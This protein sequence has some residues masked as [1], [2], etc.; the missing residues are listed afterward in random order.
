MSPILI[1]LRTAEDQRDAVHRAV[2]ALA[3]GHVVAFPT[4]TVY[5][6]AASALCEPAV[7][8]LLELKGRDAGK[9]IAL[10]IKSP[11]AALD[12]VPQLS[13]LGRRLARRCWPGP[14]TLV[15]NND[16]P[17]S[18]LSQLP[19]RVR[20][21]VVP[22]TTVGLRVPAHPVLLSVL[23]LLPGPLVLTSANRSG[24]PEAETGQD[25]AH[26]FGDQLGLV[27]DEGR[28]KLGQ[29]SSV[30]RVDGNQLEMLRNGAV[31]AAN[32]KRLASFAVLLVCTGNTCRSPMA[33]VLLKRQLADRLSVPLDGLEDRGV[34]VMSA[35][36]AAMA[37]SRS[38]PEAVQAMADRGLNLSPH[39]SQPLTD[40]LVRFADLIL[41]MTRG[42]QQ[43]IRAQW[44]EATDRVH[45]LSRDHADISDPI[46]GPPE[47]Y[48]QCANQ[49][50]AQLQWWLQQLDLDSLLGS[51]VEPA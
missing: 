42:H 15:V 16:H 46:G 25:V 36:I 2:Q 14:V 26:L 7:V 35:G 30:V 43:A 19:P 23:R 10:A 1:D 4:E 32:L 50:E 11:D 13:E 39:E 5:G 49:I 33:E 37:G 40:R 51:F 41:T 47:L 8:R 9:A 44:P 17:D 22:G 3:E 12:Y 21:A 27:L 48:V 24:E 45:L 38:T 18:V 31:N 28:C 20:Q 29:P 6:L 34:M